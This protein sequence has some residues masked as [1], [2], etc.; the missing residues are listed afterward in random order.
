MH[1]MACI[2]IMNKREYAS[3]VTLLKIIF[4]L[5][6][7][8]PQNVNVLLYS[9][10]MP[11]KWIIFFLTWCVFITEGKRETHFLAGRQAIDCHILLNPS[12]HKARLPLTSLLRSSPSFN[13]TGFVY[14][15]FCCLSWPLPG[16][17]TLP[18]K[19][20]LIAEWFPAS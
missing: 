6:K 16:S 20:V 7:Y 13:P 11:T 19:T 4:M 2:N 8:Q 18:G 17:H 10:F 12:K 5:Q 15:D 3:T 14:T 1:P 9:E